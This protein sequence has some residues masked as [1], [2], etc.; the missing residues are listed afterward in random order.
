MPIHPE[1]RVLYPLLVRH[2]QVYPFRFLPLV[3]KATSTKIKSTHGT[4]I[5]SVP[6]VN[7]CFHGSTPRGA[8]APPGVAICNPISSHYRKVLL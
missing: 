5:F 1:M 3:V 8:A 2:Q 7:P 6:F 4:V